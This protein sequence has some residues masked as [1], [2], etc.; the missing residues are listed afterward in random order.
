MSYFG[1]PNYVEPDDHSPEGSWEQGE[2]TEH[3]I[4][5]D[6]K[7]CD[8]RITTSKKNTF[9]MIGRFPSNEE[10]A[11]WDVVKYL[12]DYGVPGVFKESLHLR[13]V[14]YRLGG[15]YCICH[16]NG[17]FEFTERETNYKIYG[18][19]RYEGGE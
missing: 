11:L 9:V 4:K 13:G 14:Q 5:V 12:R 18:E 2:D 10:Q 1:L 7:T 19:T 3:E 15:L 6:G 16:E 8:F 17:L